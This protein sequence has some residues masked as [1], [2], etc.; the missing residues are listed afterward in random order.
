MQTWTLEDFVARD[1]STKL[2]VV[3]AENAKLPIILPADCTGPDRAASFD[4]TLISTISVLK[5]IVSTWPFGFCHTLLSLVHLR[6]H[7]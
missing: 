2:Q 4:E 1:K 7:L 3:P 6:N 5:V